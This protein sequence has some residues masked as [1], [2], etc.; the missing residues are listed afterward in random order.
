MPET[1]EQAE[2]KLQKAQVQ[3][4]DAENALQEKNRAIEQRNEALADLEQRQKEVEKVIA[5]K[6]QELDGLSRAAAKGGSGGGETALAV[7]KVIASAQ[8]TLT[9][10]REGIES[11]RIASLVAQ[12]NDASADMRK[13]ATGRLEREHG[14]N[15][16]AIGLVLETLSEQN[17]GSLSPSGRINALYYLNQSNLAA[18]TDQHRKQALDA[19]AR[20]R[21]RAAH[22]TARLGTQTGESL[23]KLERKLATSRP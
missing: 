1:T 11:D 22:G 3:I 23:E 21:S 16:V 14:A 10:A 15:P 19:I 18:W 5:E 12:M 9:E 6:Q 2:L 4:A 8:K 7:Q 13:V 17:L 20:I